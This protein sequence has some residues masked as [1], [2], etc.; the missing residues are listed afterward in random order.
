M[1]DTTKTVKLNFCIAVVNKTFL[2]RHRQQQFTMDINGTVI[3][4]NG[5]PDSYPHGSMIDK[6]TMHFLRRSNKGGDV[7]TV[8]YPTSI[9]GQAYV[10]MS[11]VLSEVFEHTHVLEVDGLFYPLDIKRGYHS[12]MD[13]PVEASLDLNMFS[14]HREIKILLKEHGFRMSETSS[15]QLHLQGSFLKLKAVRRKLM[16]IL[17]QE[18]QRRTSSPYTNG[19]SNGSVST[20]ASYDPYESIRNTTPS[21]GHVNGRSMYADA[22]SPS[23]G[24]TSRSP[25]LAKNLPLSRTD[26][27]LDGGYSTQNS[28][29]SLTQTYEYSRAIPKQSYLPSPRHTGESSFPVDPDVFRYVMCFRKNVIEKIESD[30]NTRIKH[31]NNTEVFTVKLSG[32]TCEEAAQE[33]SRFMQEISESLRTQEIDLKKLNASQQKNISQ[34]ADKFQMLWKVLITQEGDILKVVGSSTD[35]YYAKQNILGRESEIPVTSHLQK[36]SSLRRSHSLPRQTWFKTEDQELRRSPDVVV[37]A[38]AVSSYSPS[39]YQ[40]DST[41]QQALSKDRGRQRSKSTV[42]RSRA[43]CASESRHKT[44]KTE[45]KAP[46]S[47]DKQDVLPS[48]A[49]PKKTNPP[50]ILSTLFPGNIKSRFLKHAS[51]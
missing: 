16:Q 46:L 15:G 48:G 6:L 8:I 1:Q 33:L 27:S 34:N 31:E 13:M 14:S 25:E 10:V 35:S 2:Y 42:Q 51:N 23:T 32:G 43:Q 26:S 12:Q 38:A 40:T 20:S 19:Y 30:H 36:N 17:A 3:E 9:K 11:E 24:A 37:Q 7:L 4:V 41:S 49:A 21:H 47:L 45:E 44:H 39:R 50:K 18:T 22:W 5:L 28:L 29:S